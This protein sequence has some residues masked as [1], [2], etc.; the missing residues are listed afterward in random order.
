MIGL[1]GSYDT[2]NQNGEDLNRRRL[3]ATAATVEKGQ[4]C[5][6]A[7]ETDNNLEKKQ[8]KTST[9]RGKGVWKSGDLEK[10]GLLG[11][12]QHQKKKKSSPQIWIQ[13]YASKT[14]S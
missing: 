9:T 5:S 14:F 4:H 8:V 11:R 10:K 12:V 1:P 13:V 2:R 7:L 6:I 3:R